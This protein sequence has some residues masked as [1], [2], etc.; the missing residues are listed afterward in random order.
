MTTLNL[1]SLTKPDTKPPMLTI[2]GTPGVGK[3]SLGAL[4][5]NAIMMRAED[6]F[7]VFDDW[8]DEDKPMPLPV[9]P[10]ADAKKNISTKEVA[11]EQ[12]R[13]L[14]TQEHPFK[15][16]IVDSST[17]L[18]AL[19]EHELCDAEGEDSVGNCSGGFHKGYDTVARMHGEFKNACEYLRDK[20]G[21]TVIFLA[22][23]GIQKI[24]NRPDAE[25]FSVYS[26]DMNAKSVPVYV[27]LVDAVYYLRQDEF[28]KG[29]TT[30]KKGNVT[31]LG[32]IVQTGDR[33]LVTAGDG[34][35]GYVNAKSRWA[36][37]SEIIVPIGV[38]P[39]LD[40][41]PYFKKGA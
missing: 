5:P 20:K 33:I 10:R 15:T 17:S 32:K 13:A 28:V 25:E 16:L 8:K 39:L 38:N 26:L 29:T 22:H 40:L 27:N 12:L 14:A 18:N 4:F 3:T 24:K 7:S 2:V 1:S 9:L 31:K 6:G 23:T 41:I 30:D 19:F 37:D 36:M 35:V 11:L 34:K 21:M